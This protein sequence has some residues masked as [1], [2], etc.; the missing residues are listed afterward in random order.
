[1]DCPF[2]NTSWENEN[3]QYCPNCGKLVSLTVRKKYPDIISMYQISKLVFFGFLSF[4]G[5]YFL[6]NNINL[7]LSTEF[8]QGLASSFI[9]YYFTYYYFK[10]SETDSFNDFFPYFKQFLIIISLLMW[11]T[12]LWSKIIFDYIINDISI[13]LFHLVLVSLQFYFGFSLGIILIYF[14]YDKISKRDEIK[15]SDV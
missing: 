7:I 5:I 12:I 1:M 14:Y 2:C 9:T 10:K 13:D 15:I 8:Y 11:F 4:I 6:F 3:Q